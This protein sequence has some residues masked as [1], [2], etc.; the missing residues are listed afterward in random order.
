MEASGH[1]SIPISER[2]MAAAGEAVG[3]TGHLIEGS[4]DGVPCYV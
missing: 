4:G 3:W 1:N 2:F